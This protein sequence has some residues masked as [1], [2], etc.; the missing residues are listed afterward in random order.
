MTFGMK[1]RLAAFVLAITLLVSLIVWVALTSARLIEEARERMTLAQSES[2][3]IA[4][5]FRQ[6]NAGA[7]AHRRHRRATPHP[8]NRGD[9]NSAA[10]PQHD[11]RSRF[12]PQRTQIPAKGRLH[13]VQ[14]LDCN[15]D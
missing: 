14:C 3:R 15:G 1:I 2:F 8:H 5:Q 9:Q 7:N 4:M 10:K 11:G 13:G 12:T 6:E